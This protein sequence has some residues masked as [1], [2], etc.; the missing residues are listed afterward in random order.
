[1][2]KTNTIEL[3]KIMMENGRRYNVLNMNAHRMN[4]VL[5]HPELRSFMVHSHING[6]FVDR[7]N[8]TIQFVYKTVVYKD[9]YGMEI[10]DA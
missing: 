10:K 4:D 5:V 9:K 1:M 7:T 2:E 8:D 3:A 6:K